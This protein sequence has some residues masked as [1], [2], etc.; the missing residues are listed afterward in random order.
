LI[1]KKKVCGI[2][3]ETVFFKNIKFAV[4]GIGINIDRSPIIYNYPTTYLNF[5]TNKKLTSFKIYNEI[6][7]NFEIYLKK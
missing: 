2:L 7:K 4:I 5:F 6:K 3:Q 1:N